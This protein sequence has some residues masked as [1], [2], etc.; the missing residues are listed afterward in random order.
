MR[1]G[2]EARV[3]LDIEGINYPVIETWALPLS[4]PTEGLVM[5]GM[6]SS[7]L[8]L[9]S[10]GDGSILLHLTADLKEI[11]EISQSSTWLDL[12]SRTLAASACNGTIVQITE[13]TIIITAEPLL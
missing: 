11:E 4:A 10:V 1:F 6:P 5:P 2:Y 9:L 7:S 12:R 3:R 8:F 13:R